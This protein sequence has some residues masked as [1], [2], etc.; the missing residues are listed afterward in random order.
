VQCLSDPGILENLAGENLATKRAVVFLLGSLNFLLYALIFPKPDQYSRNQFSFQ[1][2]EC[3][4]QRS[5]FLP[6]STA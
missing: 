3:N 6:E 5:C 1:F 4:F 2:G